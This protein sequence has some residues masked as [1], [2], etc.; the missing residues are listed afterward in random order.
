[1]R[2][3]LL[4]ALSFTAV[5]AWGRL[6]GPPTISISCGA[7]GAELKLCKEGA[8]AW[9]KKTG[10]KVKV[11]LARRTRRPSGWRSTSSCWRRAR[12]TSTSSRST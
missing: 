7:V 1:M 6:P 2:R 11:D 5:V 10:N 8:E 4:T 9:A 3:T 12:P